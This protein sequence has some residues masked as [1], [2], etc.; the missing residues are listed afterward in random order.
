MAWPEELA[1]AFFDTRLR[2]TSEIP[3]VTDA[4]ERLFES[5]L[6]PAA[7]AA[8]LGQP[9][10]V[11]LIRKNGSNAVV[12]Q[13]DERSYRAPRNRAVSFGLMLSDLS[14]R[15]RRWIRSASS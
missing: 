3:E 2:I 10:V 12:I 6:V 5:F 14:I 4:L 8:A 13:V 15:S 11:C 1:F 9:D 7:G